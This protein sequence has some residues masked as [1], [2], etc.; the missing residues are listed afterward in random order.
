[1]TKSSSSDGGGGGDGLDRG[2]SGAGG[3]VVRGFLET[4]FSNAA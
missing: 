3:T 1:M 2:G 4:S